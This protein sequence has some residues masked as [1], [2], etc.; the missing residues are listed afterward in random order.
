[1]FWKCTRAEREAESGWAAQ[2][3][4]VNGSRECAPDDCLTPTGDAARPPAVR[5][6]V[7]Q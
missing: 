4:M 3:A 5:R 6:A 2:G 1:M 7:T